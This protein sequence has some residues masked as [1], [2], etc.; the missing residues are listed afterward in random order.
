MHFSNPHPTWIEINLS[1]I[2]NNTRYVLEKTGVAVL[3]VV[4]TNAYGHGAVETS[5]AV[6][7]AG[8]T[9]L[10]V[11]RLEEVAELR[12]AGIESNIMLFGGVTPA[13]VDQ[14]LEMDAVLP[15]YDL[16]LAKILSQRA[17]A[18]GKSMRVHIKVDTG[19]GR[20]GVFPQEALEF[21]R[22]LMALERLEVEGLMSHLAVT[23]REANLEGP[24]QISRFKSVVDAF[25]KEG[26]LPRWVHLASSSAILQEPDSYFNMVRAG[27]VIYGLGD[28]SDTRGNMLPG[29]RRAFTWK[30]QLMSVKRFPEEWTVGYGATYMT[31]KNEVIGVV[32][33]G[34]GDGYLR[35][36]GGEVLQDGHRV[37]I[38]GKICMDQMMV[39]LPRMVPLGTTV[40]LV[41]EQEGGVIAPQELARRW[42][43]AT[44]AVTNVNK[45]IPRIY[46]RDED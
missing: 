39:S 11:V 16:E 6:L 33:V 24:T 21:A 27:G 43:S 42:G 30:A 35:I 38:V 5:R 34:H 10:A 20:F 44:T 13:E 2:E 8:A 26:I 3:A 23:G 40:V 22:Q 28:S 4:K 18:L 19:M 15:M 37:P 32:P 14:A 9:W 46:V 1:A 7:H 41:G 36:P 31:R 29:L 25:R 17:V 12:K 45:R